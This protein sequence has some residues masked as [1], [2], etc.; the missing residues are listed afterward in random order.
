MLVRALHFFY[1]ITLT[2]I[3]KWGGKLLKNAYIC[4]LKA[5]LYC[6][7]CNVMFLMN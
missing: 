1:L 3:N 7:R 2:K 6:K 5:L 4:M